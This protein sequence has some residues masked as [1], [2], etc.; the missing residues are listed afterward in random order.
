MVAEVQRGEAAESTG[1]NVSCTR[2]NLKWTPE[3]QNVNRRDGEKWS[4]QGSQLSPGWPLG[5]EAALLP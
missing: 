5:Q 3:K 4:R 2:W 1:G